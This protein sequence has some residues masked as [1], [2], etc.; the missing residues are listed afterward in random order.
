MRPNKT[1]GFVQASP[2]FA[3]RAKLR[4]YTIQNRRFSPFADN[5][6]IGSWFLSGRFI[7]SHRQST[8]RAGAKTGRDATA[9]RP[10]PI[11]PGFCSGRLSTL[12][13]SPKAIASGSIDDAIFI[14]QIR[15][16]LD[17]RGAQNLLSFAVGSKPYH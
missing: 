8:L 17:A 1:F 9:M 7:G 11:A 2:G 4:P 10:I 14:N 5:Y 12:G 6:V 3:L 16:G 13:L 15:S